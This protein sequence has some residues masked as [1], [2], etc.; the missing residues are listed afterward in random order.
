MTYG[1]SRVSV[2]VPYTVVSKF[3]VFFPSITCFISSY[4]QA[5]VLITLWSNNGK[6]NAAI[7]AEFIGKILPPVMPFL[8]DG[9]TEM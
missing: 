7:P 9:D 3:I 1:K 2:R 8:R 4:V 6:Q 5:P